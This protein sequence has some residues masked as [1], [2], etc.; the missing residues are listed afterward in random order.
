MAPSTALMHTSKALL[1]GLVTLALAA[2]ATAAV[3]PFSG[4]VGLSLF[5]L[6]PIAVTGTGIATIGGSGGGTHVGTLSIPSTP[7]A[8]TG[9]LVPVTDPLAFPIEGLQAT[10]HNGAGSFA[11]GSGTGTLNGPM[12]L[13]GVARFCLL[14]SCGASPEANVS[15]PLSV[16]GVGGAQTASVLVNATVFG[17]PW[18]TGTLSLGTVTQMGFAHG[19]A[20]GTS[21]TASASGALRLVTP[22]FIS[23]NIFPASSLLTFA[24][25]DLHVPEP[26]TLLLL[27]SGAVGVV[28]LGR[29]RRG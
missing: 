18:T 5:G 22:I 9:V 20:S 7:F 24:V 23:T 19:P 29:S 25:L 3:V 16:I 26:G 2:P 28:L 11:S 14:A 4:G 27:G 12:A 1:V 17:N 10:L 15:V 6:P 8:T 13:Q 21:S